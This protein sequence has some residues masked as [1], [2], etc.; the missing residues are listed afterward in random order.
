MIFAGR[1]IGLKLFV[2]PGRIGDW[3]QDVS[4]ATGLTHERRSFLNHQ[5]AIA[6][7]DNF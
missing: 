2:G 1:F 4:D 3:L 7:A 5:L 6:S